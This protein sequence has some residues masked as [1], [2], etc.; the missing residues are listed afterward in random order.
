M[1]PLHCRIVVMLVLAGLLGA[2]PVA[3][4]STPPTTAFEDSEG[5]A[6]TDAEAEQRFLAAVDR[7]SPRMRRHVIGRTVEGRPLHLVEV[8]APG[9]RGPKAARSRPTLLFMCTQH[10]NEPAGRE[11]CLQ[12]LRDLSFTRDRAL[13]RL[14]STT[15]VLFVPTVNP[16]GRMADT[17]ENADGEDINR[18]HLTLTTPEIRA[19]AKVVRAWQ[20]D[21]V[22]DHHE[23]FQIGPVYDDDVMLLWP[24]NLN[25]DEPLH[26]L[27]RSFV[28]DHLAGC[29]EEAGYS[30]DEYGVLKA[31]DHNLA[32][33]QGNHDEGIAR[34]TMGLRH[35]LGVLVESNWD[36]KP[37][38]EL[39]DPAENKR[40]RV[41]SHLATMEC[42]LGWW[43]SNAR[44]A[45]ATSDGSRVRKAREGAA[46]DTP[47]YF[48]GQ[49]EDTSALPEEEPTSVEENP[50]CGY[51]L[52]ADQYTSVVRTLRLHGI[53]V[54]AA[55][56]GLVVPMAQPA[57]PVIPLLLDERGARH[58]VAGE[59]LDDCGRRKRQRR[60]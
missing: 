2:A 26:D 59:P 42:T 33:F 20:P 53:K 56:P 39:V 34:N 4:N 14:L 23:Y 40:R 47:I 8:G 48:D 29:T 36:A 60:D 27:A 25:V 24:R 21:L 49:Y 6:W 15:T 52:G 12:K 54:T 19:V 38:T 50:P 55:K 13:L 11:A 31:D 44:R 43:Q 16:D 30:A 35:A 51:R 46:R 57:E 28:V 22:I 9:P 32:Q 41:D 3:A 5:A 58:A 7:R 37:G 45:A 1:T 17:R 10:G 18:D